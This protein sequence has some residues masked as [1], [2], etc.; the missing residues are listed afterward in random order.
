MGSRRLIPHSSC[1]FEQLLYRPQYR[2]ESTDKYS[3][4]FSDRER[5]LFVLVGEMSQ[6]SGLN[7]YENYSSTEASKRWQNKQL[8]YLNDTSTVFQLF[9]TGTLPICHYLA[10]RSVY[11]LSLIRMAYN[12]GSQPFKKFLPQSNFAHIPSRDVTYNSCLK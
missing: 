8:P 11:G 4:P 2:T 6:E 10:T 7:W 12:S 5:L 1:S 9:I 3:I